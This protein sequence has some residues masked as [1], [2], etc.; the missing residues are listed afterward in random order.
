VQFYFEIHL[1]SAATEGPRITLFQRDLLLAYKEK[2]PDMAGVELKYYY[3]H[4]S[5]WLSSKNVALSDYSV[6]PPYSLD[7]IK[8][9]SF[10][11][12]VDN[13]ACLENRSATLKHFFTVES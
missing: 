10:P 3:K 13:K 11:E 4:A 6:V 2:D 12:T 7:F 5:K 8:C 1:K 9:G